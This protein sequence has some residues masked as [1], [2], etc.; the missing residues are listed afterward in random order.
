MKTLLQNY[1]GRIAAWLEVAV[2]TG[3]IVDPQLVCRLIFGSE[4]VGAGVPMARFAG[5]GLLSLGI[6]YLAT[7]TTVPAR[8]GV[9]GLLVF[10]AA[11]A[12]LLAC[13]GALTEL[14]GP[15]LWPAVILHGAIAAGLGA[16][17]SQ[18]HSAG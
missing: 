16:P 15:L 5:I 18:A 12:V 14:H 4:L 7:R 8:A 13:V 17:S 3:L 11:A 10:N 6:G 1:L 2:G 9:F